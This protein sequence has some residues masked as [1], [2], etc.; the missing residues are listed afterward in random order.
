MRPWI[1]LAAVLVALGCGGAETT[2]VERGRR[3]YAT[4]CTACHH[5][6]PRLDGSVGPAIAGTPAEVVRARVLRGEYPPGYTPKRASRLMPA[7]PFL[8]PEI[9]DLVAYLD[10]GTGAP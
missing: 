7:Q 8:A 2:A 10:A 5:P 6:D 9:E 4:N 1:A 3:I